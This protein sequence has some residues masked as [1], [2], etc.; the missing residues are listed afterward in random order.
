MLFKG[1]AFLGAV[2]TTSILIRARSV[3]QVHSSSARDWQQPPSG[4]SNF[5]RRD[6][7][8]ALDLAGDWRFPAAQKEDGTINVQEHKTVAEFLPF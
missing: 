7:W 3:V 2:Q 1:P 4:A 5:P 8:P 6:L